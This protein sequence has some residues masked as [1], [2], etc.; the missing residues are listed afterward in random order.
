MKIDQNI[1]FMART[2]QENENGGKEVKKGKENSTQTIFAGSLQGDFSLQSR[3]QQKRERARKQAMKVVN[4]AWNGD[5]KIYEE[6]DKSNNHAK[7]LRQEN[8][9]MRAEKNEIAQ[10]MEQLRQA[11]G[12]DADSEEQKQLELLKKQQASVNPYSGE[13]LTQE[14]WEQLSDMGLE[15][16]EYQRQVLELNKISLSYEEKLYDNTK[17]IVEENSVV[18]GVRGERRK[19]HLMTEAQ[20]DAEEIM[21]AAEDEIIGMVVDDAKEKLEEEK[22]EREEEA[23]EIKEEKEKQEELL[24][25]RREKEDVLEE[26]V[27]ELPMDKLADMDQAMTEVKRQIQNILNEMTLVTEDIK[28]SQVDVGI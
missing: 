15:R 16:T 11:Y 7:E 25:E 10:K 1:T 9:E 17:A 3:I 8:G 13:Q 18:R 14:E 26:L 22:E 4:D 27:E 5:R 12:V 24:E 21:E 23:A 6:I 2:A 19:K 20:E 28:G